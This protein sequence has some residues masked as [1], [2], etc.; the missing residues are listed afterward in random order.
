MASLFLKKRET[1]FDAPY[2]NNPLAL[3]FIKMQRIHA[4]R[5]S[6]ADLE[7]QYA[8][9]SALYEAASRQLTQ[10]Q[11]RMHETMTLFARDMAYVDVSDDVLLDYVKTYQQN[12]HRLNVEIG[13]DESRL[14]DSIEQKTHVR[15]QAEAQRGLLVR[16]EQS[17]LLGPDIFDKSIDEWKRIGQV[18]WNTYA[19][20]TKNEDP[21][22]GRRFPPSM[23]ERV[24]ARREEAKQAFDALC[25]LLLSHHISATPDTNDNVR[26]RVVTYP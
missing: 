7:A 25:Q 11:Q 21:D 5:A 20:F 15:E 12:I 23:R 26:Y 6:V 24:V 19:A 9:L 2:L 16:E 13:V 17:V 22:T 18:L 14:A 3:F 10:S 8:H 4:L 1:V